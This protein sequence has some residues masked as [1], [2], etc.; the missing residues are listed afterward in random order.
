MEPRHLIRRAGPADA[1]ALAELHAESAVA[2]YTGMLPCEALAWWEP[3]GRVARLRE[4]LA[5]AAALPLTLVAEGAEGALA[6]MCVVGPGHDDDR[7][8][9]E[10]H[11]LYVAPAA[12]GSGLAA[13]L[14]AEGLA[15][16]TAAGLTPVS[17]WVLEENARARRFYTRH[18][19]LADGA[20]QLH[21][22][23]GVPEI[24]MLRDAE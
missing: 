3:S 8:G 2:A 17:L 18:G 24:R 9:G 12:W 23:L 22:N 13:Q 19:F 7:P 21:P 20:R 16:L 10:L 1:Q 11:A 6:G 14:L 15:R 5:D 4:R